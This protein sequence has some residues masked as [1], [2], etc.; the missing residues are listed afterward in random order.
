M[1][2]VDV[3][4]VDEYVLSLKTLYWRLVSSLSAEYLTDGVCV[5][6]L[7]KSGWIDERT[8]F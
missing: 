5:F 7:Y 8:L 3:Q 4:Q 2:Y 1:I 6:L